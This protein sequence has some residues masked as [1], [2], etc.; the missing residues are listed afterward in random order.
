MHFPHLPL[1]CRHHSDL[2]LLNTKLDCLNQQKMYFLFFKTRL[3]AEGSVFKCAA[4]IGKY[5]KY[6][7]YWVCLN[8]MIK[9]RRINNEKEICCK[10]YETHTF[11]F[12]FL[13]IAFCTPKICVSENG[14][15]TGSHFYSVFHRFRQAK[16]LLV[17][18]FKPESFFTTAPRTSKNDSCHKSGQNWIKNSNLPT[19]I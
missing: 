10:K 7:E 8:K 14:V 2:Q 6:V 9:N 19:L 18:Q 3:F 4:N 11:S 16:L 5:P 17:I 1:N 13:I 12:V 15:K